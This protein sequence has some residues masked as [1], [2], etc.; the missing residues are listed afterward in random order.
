MFKNYLIIAWRNVLK[1]KTSS[2]INISGLA[3]G[4]AVAMMIGL[5]IRDEL[6]FNKYHKNYE[7]IVQV[8]QRE[9]FL[10]ATKVWDQMPYLL[11]NELKTNDASD[12]KY[13]TPS[14]PAEDYS[15][16]LGD[17]KLSKPGLFIDAGGPEM[18]TLKML[19]GNW[20]GLNDPHSILVS[21]SVAK[22]LFGDADPMGRTLILDNVWDPSSRLDVKI[23]GLYE[24]LP[25]NT[26][27]G[28]AKFFLPWS[29]YAAKNSWIV[30]NGWD[31]HRFDIYAELQ[32]DADFSRV[33]ARIKNAEL[34]II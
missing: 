27:F 18:L 19:K 4:M 2:F 25:Q 24:D 3:V 21:A 11:V 13:I 32:P 28:E 33:N 34:E 31:D 20:A 26:R 1:N 23:T 6:S 10:W 9:K 22:A 30:N 7:R 15:L 14:I 16:S 8:I 29:L 12:F 5:W 17:K